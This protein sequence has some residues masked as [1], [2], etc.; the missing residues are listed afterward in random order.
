[1]SDVM[2]S[3]I[4]AIFPENKERLY[5]LQEKIEADFFS[6]AYQDLWKIIDRIAVMTGGEVATVPVINKS[7]DRIIDLPIERRA[8]IT[9]ILNDAMTHAHVGESDFKAS[10]MFLEE[11]YKKNVLGEGLSDALE[12]LTHG[13]RVGNELTY[14]VDPAVD[15]LHQTLSEI[16]RV[17]HGAM[18]EGNVFEERVDIMREL[19][20]VDTMDR[21]KTGIKPLDELTFGGVG[22]GEDRV[23]A[24]T[25]AGDASSGEVHGA[26]LLPGVAPVAGA[27]QAGQRSARP[28]ERAETTNSGVQGV[29][30]RVGGIKL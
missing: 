1:M 18:P 7:L 10:V 25:H 6:G 29:V 8:A 13:V 24:G 5:Y 17:S 27:Q 15:S 30:R 19:N 9:E 28:A 20:E 26:D 4:A 11:D 2:L 12:V 14:G 23:S 3:T 16:E 21:V 22:A